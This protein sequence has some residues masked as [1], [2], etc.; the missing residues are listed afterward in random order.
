[1][2]KLFTLIT[3]AGMFTFVACGPSTE[4]KAAADKAKQDSITAV[5]AANAAAKAAADQ[6]AADSTASYAAAEAVRSQ[7]IAD[8]IAAYEA[9]KKGGKATHK[10]VVVPKV[11]TP[12]EA[13]KRVRNG[14]AY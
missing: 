13:P 8:S 14:K 6:A 7:A 9:S 10:S 3:V 4:E 11:V 5:D 12:A 2:K 1:M